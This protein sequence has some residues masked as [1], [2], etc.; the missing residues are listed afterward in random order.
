MDVPATATMT[1]ERQ[2]E[3]LRLPSDRLAVDAAGELKV[4]GANAAALVRA[5]GSPLNVVVEE[6]IRSNYRRIRDA[7]A[8]SWPAPVRVLYSV[9]A[10]NTLA[11]SAILSE[12]GA[13]SDC[14]GLGELHVTLAAGTDPGLAVMNGSNKT[15]AE[16]EAAIEAGLTINVDGDDEADVIAGACRAG[17][18][19]RVNVRL[20][21]FPDQLDAYV[22][23]LHPTPGGYVSGLRR[24]KWGFT[25]P[26]AVP[27]VRRLL[28][29]EG[30]ELL[31][32][33]CHIGHLS[34][35]VE[36]FAAV[37]A[38]IA[39]AVTALRDE[40]G[41]APS[42]LDIGGGWPPQRDPSFRSPGIAGAPIEDVARAVAAGLRAGLP[43]GMPLPALW[44]EPGRFIVS[45]A[46]VLL[47]SAGAIRRDA[48]L[49]WMHV[50]ASTNN[51]PRI[52]S[53]RF[54]YAILPATRMRDPAT[55]VV[56]VVGSTCFRSVLGA[57]RPMPDPRRGDIVAILD[58]GM[59]AEVFAT[60]FNSVPRPAA[61]L[62]A[63]DGRAEVVRERETIDDVFRSQRLPARFGRVCA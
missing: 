11:I 36:S 9:K 63:P 4:A 37:A 7:F 62:L 59:Y 17:R 53:G 61:V 26:A 50:D 12:E 60:Q 5:F 48:G 55:S 3:Q 25:A 46:V 14:F 47:A 41:F 33:S 44:I 34:G 51:L 6:T 27:L 45:N 49:C 22:D 10:N 24:A 16:I 56:E 58:A 30:A 28:R 13:G 32:L 54:H 23:E 19:V 29:L 8:A 35:R 57:A 31:G 18:R 38:A 20:K 21:V 15:R 2:L 40:T 43:A 1:G 52:E 39:G 42:V